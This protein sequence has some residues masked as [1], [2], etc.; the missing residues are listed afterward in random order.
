VDVPPNT[1]DLARLFLC[2]FLC[3]FLWGIL[4]AGPAVLA[5]VK[6]ALHRADGETDLK[7]DPGGR[8]QAKS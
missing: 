3:P 8:W 6:P 4:R 2:P 7:A 1:V 5:A